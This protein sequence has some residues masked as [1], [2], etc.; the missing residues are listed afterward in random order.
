[1]SITPTYMYGV[2][3][4]RGVV[5]SAF[6]SEVE[7]VQA[8]KRRL[9]ADAAETGMYTVVKFVTSLRSIRTIEQVG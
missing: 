4:P 5:T 8:A 6:G 7:A 1:M 9:T 3:N 2:I